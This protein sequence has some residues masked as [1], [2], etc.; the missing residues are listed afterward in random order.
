[1]SPIDDL[2]DGQRAVLQ[3][4]LRQSKS[5]DELAGLLK[6]DP[7]GVRRRARDAVAA[8]GPDARE[9]D[10][11]RRNEIAD[12]LLGQQSASQRAATREYLEGSRDGRAWAR[13]TAAALAPI[14][15]DALPD[16]PAE[17]KEVAEAFEA[18]D[19]R[20][21]RQE[22]I[23]RSSQLGTRLLFAGAGVVVAIAIILAFS[24]GDDDEPQSRAATTPA[25][26]TTGV[27]TTPTGDKFEIVAQGNLAPPEGAESSAKGQVAIV[28]FPDNN[29]F[30]FALTA[31]GLPPSSSRGSAY[32]V[33]LYSSDDKKQFLGFPDMKVGRD[34]KLQTVS[35][36]APSTPN[37]GAVLLT[38]EKVESPTK[39]GPVVLIGRLVTA[40]QQ[41]QTQTTPA[42]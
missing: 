20:A 30:R 35:D 11:T 27:Q 36:L 16:I 41:T 19:R 23:Q 2:D 31:E 9:I 37:Y 21:A 5:Y 29:Q 24:L 42:P 8:A 14:G 12:Y 10:P 32:G 22:Q 15:G 33:W 26:A 25:S 1:M 39:P 4:L 38:R 3:L 13:A 7:A 28:R 40:Q 6:T 34:G 18:L 17:R